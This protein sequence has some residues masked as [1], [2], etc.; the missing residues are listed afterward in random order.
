MRVQYYMSL[1]FGYKLR[2]RNDMLT[3]FFA[4][5]D[6]STRVKTTAEATEKN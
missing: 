2:S 5:P 1:I 4:I 3:S 6:T